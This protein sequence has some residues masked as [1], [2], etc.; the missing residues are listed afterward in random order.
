MQVYEELQGKVA[1]VTGGAR[2]IGRGVALKLAQAG[3]DVAINYLEREDTA[4]EVVNWI[5][6]M[7]RKAVALRADVSDEVQVAAMFRDVQSEF[8]RLNIVVNNAGPFLVK[9][10]LQTTL[11]EWRAML[12]GNLT[13]AFLVSKAAV[14]LMSRSES[15]GSLVF[16]GAPNA[17]R[18]G[19]QSES[20]AYSIAKTGVVILAL[21][22]ARDL[23]AKGIR[24]NVINPGF[25][26][27]DSMTPRMREW[28]PHEVPLGRVGT[29]AN[30]ADGVLYLVSDQASYVTGSVLNVH[31]GLWI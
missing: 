16:I 15:G 6:G 28:M 1:L 22:L 25:V 20:P 8:G 7:G 24:V 10:I 27:N 3:C 29:P 23:A 9:R 21:T 12:D 18:V 13:S 30:I 4:Q 14:E 17:E 2:G 26:E 31:G 19:S 11:A 5:N